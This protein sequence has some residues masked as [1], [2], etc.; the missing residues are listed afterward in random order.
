[1]AEDVF[2]QPPWHLREQVADLIA[3]PRVKSPHHH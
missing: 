3:A 1:M 2:E